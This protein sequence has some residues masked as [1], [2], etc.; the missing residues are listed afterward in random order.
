MNPSREPSSWVDDVLADSFPASDPPSWTLGMARPD[1]P[2]AARS[3]STAAPG[4]LIPHFDVTDL[5][6][7]PVAYSTIWQR[8]NLVLVGIPASDPDGTF[9][10]YVAQLAAEG[11][12]LTGEDT[13][14]VI[15]RDP[16][17]GVP[18]P[19]VVVADRWGEVAHVAAGS[20]V[21][22]LPA[23]GEIAEWV[24]YVQH[25]CPECQGET[26]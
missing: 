23:V 21:R 12:A 15:T 16:V 11:P 20:Q 2:D 9:D 8:R 3:P 19:G 22:D 6:G 17:A 18:C 25:Q 24:T 14:W 10:H 26:K 4:D 13:A 1:V 5:E 7:R